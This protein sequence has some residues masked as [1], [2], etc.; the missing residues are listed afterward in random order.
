MTV[1]VTGGCGYIGSHVVKELLKQGENVVVI[2]D[3][4]TGRRENIDSNVPLVVGSCGDAGLV[5]TTLNQYSVTSLIHLAASIDV[6]ESVKYP[7]MYYE[8]NVANSLV[9]WKVASEQGIKCIVLA[10]SCAIYGNSQN[11]SVREECLIP[12]SPYGHSKLMAEQMLKDI[13]QKQKINYAILRYFNVGGAVR[14]IGSVCY[15]VAAG[16]KP[17]VTIF[18][19]SYKTPDGTCVRDYVHVKDVSSATVKA[20][21]Y[22]KE[23]DASITCNI[24]SGKG[25]SVLEV[26]K[27][28]EKIVGKPIATIVAPAR[29]GDAIS[30]I[31]NIDETI[32]LLGW[33]PAYE[34]SEILKYGWNWFNQ[35]K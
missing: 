7:A 11:P 2:D 28:V 33:H 14:Q 25:S 18:G 27:E 26:I 21:T 9:L 17:A 32:S 13:S 20:L 1:L 8:N 4:S 3:L 35:K 29:A 6:G 22:I 5:K 10:S 34:L 24:G 15:Q 19:V 12:E 31:A 23:K 16:V 30:I